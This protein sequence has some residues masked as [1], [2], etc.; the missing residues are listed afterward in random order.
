MK[1]CLFLFLGIIFI[2]LPF[3]SSGQAGNFSEYGPIKL[4]P[5]NPHYFLYKG[6]PLALITSAEHYGSLMNLE[7]DYKKYLT[8]LEDEG[9]NYTRIFSGT[10]TEIYGESFGIQKN[11]LAPREN[12]FCT[13]WVN[14]EKEIGKAPKYDL[15]SW[16]P[17]Y[18]ERLR[19]IISVAKQQNIIVEVTLF[20]SIY[21]DIHWDVSPQNPKNT[22]NMSD[23]ITRYQAQTL[24]NGALLQYQIRFVEK[25][26]QELNEYDNFFFEIQNEPWADHPIAVYNIINKEELIPDDWT[27][28]ADFASKESMLW[29]EKIAE[30]I[31]ETE[32]TLP[33]KHL[34]AQNYTNYRAP[35]PEVSKNISIINFHYAWP[36]AARW[37]YHFDRVI[38]SDETG[39]A[40]REDVVYRRQAW[41]FIFSGGGLY[42]SLDYSFYVGHEDGL[43]ENDA[44]GGGGKALR[45][46]LS[47]LSKFLHS[48]ELHKLHPAPELVESAAGTIPY[49]MANA[50]STYAVYLRSIGSESA[51]VNL[52][53]GNG[54]YKIEILNPVSGEMLS[55]RFRIVEE[56]VLKLDISAPEGEVAL[57]ISRQE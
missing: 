54:S 20:T 50:M 1:A 48:F 39:F 7:F 24:D 56:G 31:V 44:P 2:V 14:V 53:T 40:G 33:K 16:N 46:Q 49:I 25:V 10:Y 52:K 29:Q 30:V 15:E 5:D 23:S 57:K 36:D 11:V 21:R 12:K 22:I 47:T 19:D 45:K 37:N 55:P 3:E 18:F 43:G 35:I 41:Q 9:M 4:H 8:T 26:V 6:K 17:Y 27:Y 38:G 51:K 28:K 34:I 42:N 13:P 32:A